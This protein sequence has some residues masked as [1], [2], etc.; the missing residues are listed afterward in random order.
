MNENLFD[1]TRRKK[2][3]FMVFYVLHIDSVRFGSVGHVVTWSLDQQSYKGAPN[4]LM[5]RYKLS[6]FQFVS[7]NHLKNGSGETGEFMVF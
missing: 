1:K 5:V 7:I 4:P 6:R 3:K 2:T